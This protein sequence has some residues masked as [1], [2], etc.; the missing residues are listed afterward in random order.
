MLSWGVGLRYKP[1]KMKLQVPLP[2]GVGLP[3]KPVKMTLQVLLSWEA[4]LPYR[5]VKLLCISVIHTQSPNITVHFKCYNEHVNYSTLPS[6]HQY[7]TGSLLLQ[8]YHMSTFYCFYRY[9]GWADGC[10]LQP[11][12]THQTGSQ[13][14]HSSTHHLARDHSHLCTKLTS[15]W[16]HLQLLR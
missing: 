8:Q 2:R 6:V 1:L 13:H 14:Y 4:F 15:W 9:S 3:Y 16:P 12:S 10:L 5:P 11:V 7:F